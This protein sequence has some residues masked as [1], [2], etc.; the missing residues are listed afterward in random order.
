[1]FDLFVDPIKVDIYPINRIYQLGFTAKL[2][3]RATGSDSDM[4]SLFDVDIHS[5][6]GYP[7]PRIVW[8]RDHIPLSNTTRMTL[9]NDG[10]LIIHPYQR[11]DAGKMCTSLSSMLH[12]MFVGNIQICSNRSMFVL[13]QGP[14]VCNATNKKESVTQVAYLEVKGRYLLFV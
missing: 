9:Q 4:W 7:L 8:T 12:S 3:C 1:M 2:Q 6:E 11:E 13:V 14:Y 5:I 10:S